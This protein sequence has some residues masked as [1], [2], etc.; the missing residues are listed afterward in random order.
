MNPFRRADQ[1]ASERL[2]DSARA[3]TG[4]APDENRPDEHAT[5]RQLPP[6]SPA[7]PVAALLAAAAAP[8]RAGE[9]A[10]EEAAVAAFRAARADPTPAAADRS[11]R[12]RLTTGA[13]AW[14]G[15]VAATA[16]AGAAFAAVTR[17]RAP[18]P[19]PPP[20]A[21]TA[22][23][24]TPGTHRSTEPSRPAGPATPSPALPPPVTGAPSAG[25]PP[26]G[27]LD[28]LCR[29]WQA[30]KPAQREKALRTPRFEGLVAAAGGPAQVEAYCQRLVPEGTP[31]ASPVTPTPAGPPRAKPSP[32]AKTPPSPLPPGLRTP[33]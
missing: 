30:K 10:G 5:P 26:A 3:R 6:R 16:T 9:M 21:R 18:E 4:T 14:I 25:L 8:S 32:P 7:D 1:V 27:D 28:D 12:R 22:P 20:P 31:T 19:V 23:T 24:P 15:A 2:L 13:V 11:G 29:A 17:D 33:G